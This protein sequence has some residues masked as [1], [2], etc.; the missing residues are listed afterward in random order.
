M[1]GPVARL[2]H[3][4]RLAVL[5][6]W[7]VG[8]LG[9]CIEEPRPRHEVEDTEDASEPDVSVGVQ[10]AGD[11][12]ARSPDATQDDAAR[13]DARPS[14]DLGPDRGP[15]FDEGPPDGAPPDA[16]VQD[17]APVADEGADQDPIDFEVFDV[18]FPVDGDLDGG[19]EDA[20]VIGEDASAD[21]A[22]D[23]A[24][25]AAVV[26]GAVTGVAIAADER[27]PVRVRGAAA[28]VVAD[29][30]GRFRLAPLPPGRLALQF[31]APGHQTETVVVTVPAEGGEVQLDAPVH[32]YR[33]VRVAAEADA[34][35][36]VWRFDEAWLVWTVGDRLA[37]SPVPQPAPRTLVA[38]GHEVLLSFSPDGTAVAARHRTQPGIAGDIDLVPLDGS[39]PVRLFVEAQ[40]W[41][42]WLGDQVLAMVHTRDA[43][44]R[45]EVVRPGEA[46]RLVREGVPWLLVTD[47][48]DGQVAFAAGEPPAFEV[49]T[50]DLNAAQL[51]PRL[52]SAPDGGT[53]DAWLGNSPGRTG[54]LWV[55]DTDV[56]WRFEPEDGPEALVDGVLVSPRPR[57][58]ADGRLVFWRAGATAEDLWLFD[59]VEERRL[60]RD[61]RGS[62]FV[63][64]GDGFY[65]N[66]DG[67]GVWHGD[68]GPAN[69]QGEVGRL[70]VPGLN[71]PFIVSGGGLVALADGAAWRYTPGAAGGEALGPTGLGGLQ[72]TVSG[73]T[74]FAGATGSLWW[75]PGPGLD[76]RPVALSMGA[77]D[78]SRMATRDRTGLYHPT[79]QGWVR[80]DLPPAAGAAVRRYDPPVRAIAELLPAEQLLTIDP[81][82]ATLYAVDALDAS[83]AGRVRWAWNA[84][85]VRGGPRGRLVA[86]VCDRGLFVVPLP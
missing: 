55:D 26:L 75:L 43:L 50:V 28:E 4:A 53:V 20:E 58:L 27:V 78:Q 3:R 30:Q 33:G 69:A 32:L 72:A 17:A 34:N 60:V 24:E 76:L 36:L 37:G 11:G 6:L 44:S 45:L 19:L 10:D 42:R 22:E 14:A 84:R 61:T 71:T 16:I 47:L 41:V 31:S 1:V 49:F 86:Y 40:P 9:A 70:A 8:A 64:V 13:P 21:A 82:D 54:L 29:A 39:P 25:D 73:A 46:P 52:A 56:L 15:G 12:D 83:P 23:A 85:L 62:T 7:T 18:L 48:V 65:V 35:G 81:A 5:L 80:S 67:R 38:S 57:Y 2:G 51:A 63:T 68:F 79:A 66:A 77:P 59:G 74:A